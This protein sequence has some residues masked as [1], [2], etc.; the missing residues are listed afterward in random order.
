MTDIAPI[1]GLIE[2]TDNFTGPI[3]LAEAA[4]SN[5]SKNNQESLKAVAGSLGIVTA[6]L[7]AAAAATIELG[8][9]GSDVNDVNA[10]LEHFAGGAG[11]AKAAMDALR[12]GTKGTV[13]NFV[14]AKDAAH[15]LSAGV[16][17]TTDDFSTLGQAAFV[18][19]NRGLGGTKEQLDLVSDAL[20]TGRTR[21]LAMALGVIDAGDAEENYARKLGVSKD[22]L[23]VAGQAEAKRIEVMRI[24]NA[25][26]K[27]AGDQQ[28]DFGEEFEFVKAQV[29]NYVDELGSG[30]A[31]STV[32]A[33]G[34]KA[35]ET[36][37]QGAFNGDK[38]ASIK[39]IVRAIESG[40]IMAIDFAQG[41][42]T[43]ARVVEGAWEGVSAVVLGFETFFVGFAARVVQG[44]ALIA[45]AGTKL[46]IIP[47]DVT[48]AI[49]DTSTKL[50]AMTSDLASQ[51]AEA[52]RAVVGHTAFDKTLDS[53]SDGL[54]SV[55][56]AMSAAKLAT[57]EDTKAKSD[58]SDATKKNAASQAELNA[59]M[60]DQA[61]IVAALTKSSK[62]LSTVW[63]DYFALVAKTSGT[64]RDQQIGDIEATFNKQ[65][66]S[67]DA[68]D[69]LFDAKY[70]AY[71]AIADEQLKGIASDWDSVKDKSIEGMQAAADKAL[72]TWKRMQDGGLHFTRDV[73]DAQKAKWRE[74]QDAA[75]GWGTTAKQAIGET[76]DKVKVL[77]ASWVTDEDVAK[78]TINRTTIMVKTLSGELVTLAE[79]QRRQREGGSFDVTSQN[80]AQTLQS[81]ITSGGWNP[82]GLGSNIDTAKAYDFARQGYSFQ[83]ILQI[84]AAMKTSN[85]P[86]P[87]PRGPRIPGFAM[88]GVVDIKTGEDGPEVVRVPLGSTVYP[89]GTGPSDVRGG[90]ITIV[91]YINGTA[92][93]VAR[94]S[95]RELMK[96]LKNSRQFPAG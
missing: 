67:L 66:S 88:G 86:P 82:S 23:S 80:F 74:L 87:P 41:T 96:T 70:K 17:L 32:F 59:K 48:A 77:D 9:R 3:G 27:D 53:L 68:L 30:I 95:A 57:V 52:A 81:V 49:E 72:E 47:A 33:A 83:E 20:V 40:A 34:F 37:V 44:I 46:H 5:F 21:A 4:L 62:E 31:S 2:L 69:P 94:K 28:R 92:D 56:G 11:A 76:A 43:M 35:I 63:D 61:K 36:A 18:L 7:G 85:Q 89:T 50:E 90:A 22:Q 38:E 58:A 75:N 25:A 10:T 12:D 19:Q 24:L 1:K 60:I 6:A 79:A 13:D 14:L 55:R 45:E 16:K 51:T 73:M 42:I 71:R 54:N 26:T 15:L 64:T 91:Q 29:V 84:F 39:A 8:K 78:A 65:V 93:E